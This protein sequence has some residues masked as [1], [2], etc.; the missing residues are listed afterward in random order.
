[1]ATKGKVLLTGASGLLGRQIYQCLKKSSWEVMGLA[2]SRGGEELVKA[3]LLDFEKMREIMTDFKPAIVIHS[4]AERRPD[5]VQKDEDKARGLNVTATQELTRLCQELGSFLVYISTDYVFDGTSPPYRHD[6][7]PNPLNTYGQLK[8]D[9]EKAVSSYIDSAIVRVPILYGPVETLDESAVTILFK[10]LLSND[11]APMSDYEK[12]YPTHTRDIGVFLEAFSSKVLTDREI[13]RGSWHFG[14]S[15]VLTKYDMVLKMAKVFKLSS[16]HL[17]PVREPSGGAPRPFN[18]EFDY[19]QTKKHF[20]MDITSF[21]DG[22]KTVLE[23]F[24][25]PKE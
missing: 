25:P 24:L 9:G 13:C 4:A 21:E 5:K 11:P 19:S 15:E 6:D 10:A 18:N 20:T 16:K 17:I 22:I 3:D 1:M 7:A 14:G 2:Y 23:P 12:R 8:L